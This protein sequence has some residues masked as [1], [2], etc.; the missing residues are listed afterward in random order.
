MERP[1]V[2]EGETSA[3]AWNRAEER[4]ANLERSVRGTT[5]GLVALAVSV[6]VF[7]ALPRDSLEIRSGSGSILLGSHHKGT[8]MLM[9]DANGQERVALGMASDGEPMLT[10]L[11][12]DGRLRFS[13]GESEGSSLTLCDSEGN[14]RIHMSVMKDV[15]R[16]YVFDA[17][18][19]PI[20][21][22]DVERK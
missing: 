9:L 17:D 14:Q 18:G 20:W 1:A 15:C 16:L 19:E 12:A 4:I 10:L 21:S 6:V 7:L 5:F 2:T 8:G 11:G 22:P 13:A 3:A